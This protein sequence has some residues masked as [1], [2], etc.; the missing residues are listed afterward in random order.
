VIIFPPSGFSE[1]FVN[2][3]GWIDLRW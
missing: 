2:I 3:K 1:I